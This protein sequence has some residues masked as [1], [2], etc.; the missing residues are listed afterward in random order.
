MSGYGGRSYG[1]RQ[2]YGARGRA[3][4][5]SRP[6]SGGGPRASRL[7][8]DDVDALFSAV[9]RVRFVAF[10]FE[11]TGLSPASDRIVEIGAV[12]FRAA[13]ENGSWRAVED[14]RYET[15]IHP[16]RPIPPEVSAIHG[17]DDL[18]VSSA[19]SFAAA[20]PGFIAFIEGSIL[21]A[22]NAPFDLGFLKAETARSGIENPSNPAYDTIAIA[23]TAISGLPS[24][25]LKA[26]ASSFNIAQTAAHRGGDDAKVC[27]ELFMHCI[28][29]IQTNN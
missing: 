9:G 21:V 23:K 24:Y 4:G 18:A 6:Y 10:D 25:S 19:P 28:N 16:G 27:M 29:L 22:H 11:T 8:L 17:I 7:S 15:L 3:E 26:L 20:A 13:Q 14:G 5:R 1:E 12:A 2:G